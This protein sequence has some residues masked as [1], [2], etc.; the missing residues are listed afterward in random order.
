MAFGNVNHHSLS[1]VAGA[2]LSAQ[3]YRAVSVD[4]NGRAVRST[5]GAPSIGILQNEP[6]SGQPATVASIG[7]I[8]KGICG[9]NITAG[10]YVT[11]DA[12]GALV[13]ATGG[14]TNTSDA[15]AAA[16]PL[17]G[18]NVIGIALTGGVANDIIPVMITLAGAVPTT[19][20]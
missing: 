5:A 7:A 15:G 18:S 4:S 2:D 10:A 6:A 20:V 3:Q 17:S 16:D 11:S 19:A 13:T 14:R 12:N 8:S 9:G 1:L